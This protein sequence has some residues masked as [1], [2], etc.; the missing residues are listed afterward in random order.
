[1]T[2]AG[3]AP[4]MLPSVNHAF[5]TMLRTSQA[6]TAQGT[7]HML[8]ICMLQQQAWHADRAEALPACMSWHAAAQHQHLC[9]ERC[10]GLC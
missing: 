7:L 8:V 10:L 3:L 9:L 1:M 5:G 4:C 6:A 2:Y